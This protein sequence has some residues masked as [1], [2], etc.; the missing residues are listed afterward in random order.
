MLGFSWPLA[1]D[2]SV[3]GKDLRVGPSVYLRGLGMHPHSRV[4]FALEGKY[5]RFEALVGLDPR[6]GRQ[7]S[8]R[9][10]V[11]AD[12]KPLDLGGSGELSERQPALTIQVPIEAVKELTLE[13]DFGARGDVQAHVNWVEARVVK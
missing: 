7:G 5:R 13:T 6:T 4:T 8:A 3:A 12:G 11:L 1:I 2:G 10:R 9:I